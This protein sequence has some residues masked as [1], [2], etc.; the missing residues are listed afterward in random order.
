MRKRVKL[1]FLR[2]TVFSLKRE[3]RGISSYFR[4]LWKK[5]KPQ[6]T[7]TSQAPTSLLEQKLSRYQDVIPTNPTSS[8]YDMSIE[9]GFLKPTVGLVYTKNYLLK[10]MSSKPSSS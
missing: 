10:S 2:L 7:S 6:N 9:E 8:Q 3:T 1:F 4:S 5:R